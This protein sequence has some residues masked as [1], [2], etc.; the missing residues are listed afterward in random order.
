MGSESEILALLEAWIA[1]LQAGDAGKVTELYASDAILLPTVSSRVR[2][3]HAEIRDYFEQVV[4]GG[5]RGVID[6]ANVRVFGDLAVS[7]G[8][9]TFAFADGSVVAARFTYVYRQS[10]DGWRIIEHHSSRVPE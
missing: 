2:R 4:A 8:R 7:S 5:P 9:Y 6:E 3:N 1:A 10:A